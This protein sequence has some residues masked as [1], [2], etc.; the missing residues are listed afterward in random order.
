MRLE[1]QVFSGI[2][3]PEA[4]LEAIAQ[5]KA[6]VKRPSVATTPVADKLRT[7]GRLPSDFGSNQVPPTPIE[8]P[9]P[10]N[11]EEL[12]PRAGAADDGEPPMYSDAPPSYE[13]AIAAT[14]PPVNAPRPNYE[15]PP[16]AEDDVLRQDEK[17]GWV[18]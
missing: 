1:I 8:T 18:G 16:A 3:P 12:P 17:K 9:G 5:A 4:L 13:D 11:L 7:E 10:S 14:L 2:K 15:P 6:N